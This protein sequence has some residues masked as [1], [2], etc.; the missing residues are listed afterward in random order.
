MFSMPNT[1][2]SQP[3]SCLRLCNGKDCAKKQA[4]AYG[5]MQ[6]VAAEAGVGVESVGCQGSCAG[7]TAVVRI[8]GELHWFERLQKRKDQA[9]VVALAAGEKPRPSKR[10]QK[11]ELTGKRR[12]KAAR[13]LGAA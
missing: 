4:K 2:K 3:L 7:P 1:T 6:K 10:L 13:K 8:D 5:R 9:E 11:L 12:R